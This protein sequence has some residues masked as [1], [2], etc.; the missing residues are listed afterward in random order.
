MLPN[1]EHLYLGL[2]VSYLDAK[3]ALPFLSPDREKLLEYDISRAIS[4]VGNPQKP[5]V[6]IMTP[7]PMFGQPMN[8]MMMRMGQQPQEPWVVLS[9]LQRD[10]TVKQLQMDVDKIDDDVKVLMVVHPKK[11]Q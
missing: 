1:G 9:E 5:V 10:F 11:Y 3:V 2:A 4:Q 6:G 8:P 7:L